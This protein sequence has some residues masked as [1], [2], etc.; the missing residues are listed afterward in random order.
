MLNNHSLKL[1]VTD[2]H[3]TNLKSELKTVKFLAL[4]LSIFRTNTDTVFV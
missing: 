3:I 4:I 2:L 1:Q